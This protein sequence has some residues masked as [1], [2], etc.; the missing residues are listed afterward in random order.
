M[1]RAATALAANALLA[2]TITG[3]AGEPGTADEPDD[4]G[5]SAVVDDTL[6]RPTRP[7]ILR[8]TGGT[9]SAPATIDVPCGKTSYSIATGT[10]R[11]HCEVISDDHSRIIAG[12]CGD[13]DS[14]VSSVDCAQGCG[15]S[16]GK[17]SC[18][19]APTGGIGP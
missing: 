5:A 11:G 8:G 10:G 13:S 19:R 3:C 14:N 16:V 6:P 7:P 17:G 15:S 9:R 12:W 1:R 4:R 18:A 2:S